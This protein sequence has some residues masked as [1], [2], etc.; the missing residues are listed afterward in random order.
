MRPGSYLGV[1]LV[2]LGAVYATNFAGVAKR[3]G[4]WRGR[5]FGGWLGSRK[6]EMSWYVNMERYFFGGICLAMGLIILATT[7]LR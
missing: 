7:A 3:Q 1:V 4:E 2:I 5:V 6:R